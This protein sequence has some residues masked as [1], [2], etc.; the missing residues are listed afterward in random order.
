MA[1]ASAAAQGEV[2]GFPVTQTL[3]GQCS[4]VSD[5]HVGQLPL[6]L[7]R[8]WKLGLVGRSGTQTQS[9]GSSFSMGP[10]AMEGDL[11]L[12]PGTTIAAGYDFAVPGNHQSLFFTVTNPQ[13]VFTLQCV[14]GATPPPSTLTVTMPTQT[15]NV[16]NDQ[17]TP[18][19]DQQ[20]SLVYQGSAT[21]PDACSGGLMTFNQGGTFSASLS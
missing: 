15:Y 16:T 5:G 14:S 4:A 2:V 7:Q 19:G 18:S 10:Q 13:V 21:V 20:S 3:S 8:Q 1:D 17:W 9:C 12:A 6:A 11:K